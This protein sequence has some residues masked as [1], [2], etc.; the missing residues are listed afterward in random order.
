MPKYINTYRGFGCRPNITHVSPYAEW[1]F[2]PVDV[3]S[4]TRLRFELI[5][6]DMLEMGNNQTRISS[7]LNWR[8]AITSAVNAFRFPEKRAPFHLRDVFSLPL[9]CRK[10]SPGIPWRDYFK[11]RGEVMDDV[12]CQNS[13]RWFWHRIK[14]G[15][16]ISSPDCCV[17]YRAHIMAEDGS[18]KIRAVYGYPTTITLCEAQFALPLIQ[19]YQDHVTPIAYKYD[20]C[21]GGAMKLRR[22]LLSYDSYGCFDFSKFDKTVSAQLIDAAFS[23]LFMNIDFTKYLGS[24]IP[25][26]VR[27]VRAWD[28]LV[29]YFKNTTMRL[30]NGE[31]YKKDAGV[32][33][34]SYFTQLVDSIVNYIIITYCWFEVYGKAPAYIKVFGDDSV[35]ADDVDIRLYAVAE[36]VGK[37]GMILNIQKSIV[38]KNIDKVEFLGFC[39]SGGFP[40]RSRR[41]WISSLY[42]PEFDDQCFG[43]FQ[44]RALGL[45][46][47]N[48]GIDNLFSGMCRYVVRSGRFAIHLSRDMRRFLFGIGV[49]PD[50]ISPN[51]PDD[52]SFYFKLIR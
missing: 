48:S 14:N 21:L 30:S 36:I 29:D 27:L 10:S 2:G 25:D 41:K 35:V 34:G 11:T 12:A 40:H 43:D 17:L 8:R 16:L 28:Y 7:S 6:R 51:M 50:D 19:G 49:D 9:E 4:R 52:S 42:H 33:S 37:L 22:E 5:K 15:E 38:T 20:M 45:F 18:P 1:F 23:I 24:G 47:A 26:S 3:P 39:I 32:P 46:Y 31:R 44:S 13:I